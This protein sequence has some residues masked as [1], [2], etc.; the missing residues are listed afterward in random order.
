MTRLLIFLFIL[1]FS[2]QEEQAAGVFIVNTPPKRTVCDNELKT[3]I[4]Q[5]KICISKKPIVAIEEIDYVTEIRYEP[6]IESHYIDIGFS[7][8]AVSTLTRTAASLPSA[9][10]ALVVDGDV[11]CLFSLGSQLG[12]RYVRIGEDAPLKDLTVIHDILRN[13]KF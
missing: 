2:F 3:V 5:V 13:T 11:I 6:K 7:S 4:G 10:F 1:P 12:L 9:K 8:S